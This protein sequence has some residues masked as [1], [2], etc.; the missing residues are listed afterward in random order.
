MLKC[1]C[2]R[3]VKLIFL[4]GVHAFMQVSAWAKSVGCADVLCGTFPLSSRVCVSW[5]LCCSV[6]FFEMREE[7][8]IMIFINF[9]VTIYSFRQGCFFIFL[10]IFT[11]PHHF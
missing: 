8:E 2:R 10:F 7:L 3:L 11:V 4:K 9:F 1:I 5:F 6:C